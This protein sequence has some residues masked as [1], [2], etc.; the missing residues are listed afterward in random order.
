M[1]KIK[2]FNTNECTQNHKELKF[3]EIQGMKLKV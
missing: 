3:S 1:K 2:L